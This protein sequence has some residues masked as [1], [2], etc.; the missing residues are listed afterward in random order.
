M[1]WTT[2]TDRRDQIDE[3]VASFAS[4]VTSID[5]FSIAGHQGNEVTALIQYSP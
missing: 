3:E 2:I 1:A 5:A 4:G